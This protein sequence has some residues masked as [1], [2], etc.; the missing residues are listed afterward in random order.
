MRSERIYKLFVPVFQTSFARPVHCSD[1][2][3]LHPTAMTRR[4]RSD[5]TVI[6]QRRNDSAEESL[7]S[8][9]KKVLSAQ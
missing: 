3:R 5:S 9:K 8:K 7:F 6:A 2:G 1:R 4:V